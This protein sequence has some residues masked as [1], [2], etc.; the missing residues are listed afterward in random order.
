MRL[1]D[2]KAVIVLVDGRTALS[3]LNVDLQA[4]WEI[5]TISPCQVGWLIVLRQ[6]VE[7]PGGRL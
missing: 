7:M 6:P 3:A 2:R 1:V 5:E 4:G